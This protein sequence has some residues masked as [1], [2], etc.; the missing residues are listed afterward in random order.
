MSKLPSVLAAALMTFTAVPFAAG[1]APKMETPIQKASYGIG[2]NIGSGLANDGVDLNVPTFLAGLTDALKK[3]KPRLS[4]QEIR[5]AFTTVQQELQQKKAAGAPAQPGNVNNEGAAFLANNAQQP[6]VVTLPSGLQYKVITP[7]TG[8]TPTAR[9]KVV[10][11][12]RGRLLN[13]TEFDSSYSRN[14]PATFPVG[15]VIAGWTE[16]LQRMKVGGKWEL[17]VPSNLA[18]GPRGAGGK[19][20]PN[21]TLIFE[22]ELLD[23]VK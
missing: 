17:Y 15:G 22:I 6:G 19:I 20:G 21:A 23:I 4:E 9:D 1:D 7:G 8:A 13:G 5:A 10:T 3:M 11:H 18:Y 2:F 16:A 14:K 12:Y